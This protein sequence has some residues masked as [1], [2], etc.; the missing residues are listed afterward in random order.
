MLVT[1]N[2]LR[3]DVVRTFFPSG[4]G[5]GGPCRKGEPSCRAHSAV[6]PGSEDLWVAGQ[7]MT[8]LLSHKTQQQ[9]KVLVNRGTLSSLCVNSCWSLEVPC[10]SGATVLLSFPLSWAVKKNNSKKTPKNKKRKIQSS[11]GLRWHT[12][13]ILAFGLQRQVDL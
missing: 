13:L 12:S 5:A 2:G 10:V 1:S 3:K 8:L 11:Q 7:T 4:L 9:D 6:T